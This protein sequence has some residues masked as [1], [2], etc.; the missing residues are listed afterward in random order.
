MDTEYRGPFL[1]IVVRLIGD[2]HKVKTFHFLLG[3]QLDK[4]VDDLFQFQEHLK[5]KNDKPVV[6][7]HTRLGSQSINF[8][9]ET[10]GPVPT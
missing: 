6:R 2:S 5:K 1:G 7:T 4:T 10:S 9:V 3:L 8:G